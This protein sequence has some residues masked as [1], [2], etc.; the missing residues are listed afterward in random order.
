MWS[1]SDVDQ[2]CRATARHLVHGLRWNTASASGLRRRGEPAQSCA[3]T[4]TAAAR[5]SSSVAGWLEVEQGADVPTHPRFLAAGPPRRPGRF[6]ANAGRHA[7][8]RNGPG[9]LAYYRRVKRPFVGRTAELAAL[10]VALDRAAGGRGGMVR[11]LGEPGIGKTR[12]ADALVETACQAGLR[13]GWARTWDGSPPFGIVC[14]LIR[15]LHNTPALLDEALGR[16]RQPLAALFPRS[17]SIPLPPAPQGPRPHRATGPSTRWR[18]SCATG[19]RRC[20]SSMICTPPISIRSSFSCV[21]RPSCAR[22]R[23]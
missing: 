8:A 22:R 4:R 10:Q 19:A 13:V 23:R 17:R 12:L 1:P 15:S 7:V 2:A 9:Q 5:I 3:R 14:A 21:W 11:L 16:Q 6:A 20:W 18:A